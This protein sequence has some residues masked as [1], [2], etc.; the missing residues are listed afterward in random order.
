[1]DVDRDNA[2]SRPLQIL[3]LEDLA[4]D[5]ELCRA[6]LE[7][8]GLDCVVQHVARREE[9]EQALK[10]SAPDLILCDFSMPGF[11]GFAALDVAKALRPGVPFIFVAGVIGEARAV[12]AVKR[13]AA[14]CILK[15]DLGRLVP[16][17]ERTIGEREAERT[18][19]ASRMRA[20]FDR[21]DAASDG[22]SDAQALKVRASEL[23]ELE[24]QLR[25]AFEERQF[26]LHYQPRISLTTGNVCGLEALIR[27]ENPD[28]GLVRAGHFVPLL[29]ANGLIIE[30]GLWALQRAAADFAAW[31]AAGLNPPS[32][33]VNVSA[34]QLR[35]ADFVGDAVAAIAASGAGNKIEIEVTE[36]TLMGDVD[37][38]ARKLQALRDAG[39]KIALD[40]FGTGYSSLSYLAQLP[41]DLLKISRPFVGAM[42]SSPQHMAVVTT[43]ISLAR[44]LKLRAVAEGVETDEEA[45]L[46]HLLR[47][48]EGQGYLYSFPVPAEEVGPMLQRLDADRA[49]SGSAWLH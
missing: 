32:V 48:D 41:A 43:I 44:S 10:E 35:A 37:A 7:R 18:E 11:D 30:V 25:R 23:V 9:F 19:R 14:D 12:E 27:W 22:A 13:G 28:L 2:S 26:V 47:C 49:A 40:D 42:T 46:L 38:N 16:V 33:A 31:H 34:V 8:G 20:I 3:I 24:R 6:A 5:A 4:A 29:E 17:I 15:S 39:V 21:I 45:R 36:S 1:M